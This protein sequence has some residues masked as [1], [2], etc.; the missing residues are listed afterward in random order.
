MHQEILQ[1]FDTYLA[2]IWQGAHG[3]LSAFWL[4]YLDI[5]DIVFGMVR[6][7]REENMVLHLQ[8]IYPII[9]CVFPNDAVSYAQYLPYYTVTMSKR[10]EGHP[11]LSAEFWQ[12]RFSVQMGSCDPFAKIP[13]DRA[14]QKLSIVMPKLLVEQRDSASHQQQWE[15]NTFPQNSEAQLCFVEWYIIQIPAVIMLMSSCR[16]S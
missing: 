2:H 3:Y 10:V 8:S 7:A 15:N 11:G 6:A 5:V 9:P 14:R 16:D 13:A 12:R 1:L 4:S